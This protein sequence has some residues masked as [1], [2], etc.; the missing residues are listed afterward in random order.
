MVQLIPVALYVALYF[1]TL[2]ICAS[3]PASSLHG[4]ILESRQTAKRIYNHTDTVVGK[5]FYDWFD[6]EPFGDKDPTHGRV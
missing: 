3:H 1:S 2:A 5:A 4:A 6:W